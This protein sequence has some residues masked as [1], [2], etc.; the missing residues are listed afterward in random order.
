MTN[1][2]SHDALVVVDVQRDFLPGGAL[3]IQDGDKI[4]PILAGYVAQFHARGFRRFSSLATGIRPTTVRFETK[5]GLGPSTVSQD[6]PAPCRHRTSSLPSR[7]SQSIRRSIGT[8]KPILHCRAHRF[9]R[10]LRALKVR[11]LF[12]G[13]L[14]TDYCVLNTVK[15]CAGAWLRCVRTHG[16]IKAVNLHPDDGRNAEKP[17][18]ISAPCPSAS[19]AWPHDTFDHLLLTDLYELTMTQAYPRS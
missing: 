10:H 14:A 15:G 5:A 9:D 18:C 19:K 8:K 17:C 2:T 12:I 1:L 4:V 7:R 16:W 13:G 3:G 11:R 6:R